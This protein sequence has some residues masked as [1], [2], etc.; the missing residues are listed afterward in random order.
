MAISQAGFCAKGVNQHMRKITLVTFVL[1]GMIGGCG[2]PP[3]R[4]LVEECQRTTAAASG[5]RWDCL[6][7]ARA[8]TED[9]QRQEYFQG[10]AK[11]CD[12]FGMQRGTPAFNQCVYQQQQI[13]MQS[14]ARAERE[15]C[16]SAAMGA[17]MMRSNSPNF[18]VALGEGARARDT[19]NCP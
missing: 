1:A 19:A 10:L 12:S 15:R 7:R 3:A 18:F 4:H 17:G 11:V 8:Q 6:Q 16:L 14:N 13:E 9:L 5:A 2:T